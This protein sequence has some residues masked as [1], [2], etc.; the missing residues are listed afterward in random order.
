MKIAVVY[1]F[2]TIASACYEPYARRFAQQYVK[3]P[4]GAVDHDLYVV[5]NGPPIKHQQEKF[6]QP[7]VPNY[8][9]HDNSGRDVGAHRLAA[10]VIP[11][12]IIVM[13]GSPVWPG[14]AGWL[15]LIHDAYL[16][17]GPGLYGAFCFHAPAPHVR[18]TCYW[19]FPDLINS[20]TLQVHDQLRYEWE[21][22]RESITRHCMK[23]GFPVLQLTWKGVYD[24]ERWCH[25]E[26]K[27]CLFFDQHT[28]RIGY[29]F[30][31]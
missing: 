5:C 9:Q 23:L 14:R 19:T 11:C 31:R 21:H 13:L 7:L 17:N 27:D 15:D 12:D 20:H 18:T 10:A 2:P 26:E 24:Y 16:D 1:V 28:E 25:V 22:G 8:L 4:P 3:H 6:F 30:G 29:G